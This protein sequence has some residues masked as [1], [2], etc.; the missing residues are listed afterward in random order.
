MEENNNI[1]Q[2]RDYGKIEVIVK[3]MMDKKGITKYEMAKRT[4]LKHQTVTA[5]YNNALQTR[6]DLD[7]LSKMCFVL[8]CNISDVLEYQ[9]PND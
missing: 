3:D 2:Y 4:G 1:I 7:V 6:V 8:K 5:Y 9:Y